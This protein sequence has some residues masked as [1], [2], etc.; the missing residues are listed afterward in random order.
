MSF[1]TADLFTGIVASF[2]AS[3]FCG[4]HA[5]TVNNSRCGSRFLPRFS[6]NLY[7]QFIMNLF[8]ETRL[9][10]TPENGINRFPF[11]KVRWQISP[12]ATGSHYIEDRIQDP[13]PIK[14]RS[15]RFC[16]LGDQPAENLPLFVCE[17]AVLLTFHRCVSVI[18]DLRNQ[19]DGVV[20]IFIFLCNS[21]FANTF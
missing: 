20:A 12:L 11:G 18:L 21:N 8:P 9:S 3:D 15:S 10:P 17:V 13:P 14:W 4:L 1:A 6:A 7:T 5:L 19:V 2:F 16:S